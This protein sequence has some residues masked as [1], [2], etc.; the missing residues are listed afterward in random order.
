VVLW[1][2]NN[3][4]VGLLSAAT[5]LSSLELLLVVVALTHSQPSQG[6]PGRPLGR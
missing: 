4:V 5:N 2:S 3:I 6:R 1:P